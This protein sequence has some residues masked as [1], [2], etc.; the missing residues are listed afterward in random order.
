MSRD[1]GMCR[2]CRAGT[3]EGEELSIL[4]AGDDRQTYFYRISSAR[5]NRIDIDLYEWT[6][7]RYVISFV[8]FTTLHWSREQECLKMVTQPDSACLTLVTLLIPSPT[9]QG[10]SCMM[11]VFLI[12]TGALDAAANLG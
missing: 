10:A 11:R 6:G 5:Y 8:G 4:L 1:A 9:R 2:P 3:L 7:T 12:V